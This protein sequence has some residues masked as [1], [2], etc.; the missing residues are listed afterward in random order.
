VLS[1]FQQPRGRFTSDEL[2]DDAW[3]VVGRA[4]LAAGYNMGAA[5]PQRQL[6]A[7]PV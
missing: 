2:A 7:C 1:H 4:L 5:A 6:A 3:P